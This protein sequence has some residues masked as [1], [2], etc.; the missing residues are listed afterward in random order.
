MIFER[1]FLFCSLFSQV[2]RAKNKQIIFSNFLHKCQKKPEIGMSYYILLVCIL[3]TQ[4]KYFQ[5]YSTNMAD[6]V[7]TFLKILF[8]CGTKGTY[9]AE[10][11]TVI[12]QYFFT[13]KSYFQVKRIF[14]HKC[15]EKPEIWL[16]LLY[17]GYIHII[18]I[19]CR[20]N[21]QLFSTNMADKVFTFL[22][23]PVFWQYKWYVQSNFG[24]ALLKI[25]TSPI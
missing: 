14:L 24:N 21:N 6:K 12:L 3:T 8:F 23:N 19:I 22:K 1:N 15:K 10:K 20:K 16:Q 25:P 7:F 11:L 17:I 18:H 5:L 2:K 4:K 9:R 13:S